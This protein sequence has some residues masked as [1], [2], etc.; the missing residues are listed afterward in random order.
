MDAPSL[1]NSESALE[2][3]AQER[4]KLSTSI[5]ELIQTRDSLDELIVRARESYASF[6]DGRPAASEVPELCCL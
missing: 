2:R 1:G 6:A 3:M 5:T 4:E